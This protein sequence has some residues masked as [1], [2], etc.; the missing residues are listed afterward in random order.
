MTTARNASI[1]TITIGPASAIPLRA[2]WQPEV[3]HTYGRQIL[4]VALAKAGHQRELLEMIAVAFERNGRRATIVIA[5]QHGR[6]VHDRPEQP[7]WT[8]TGLTSRR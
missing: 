1:D 5:H 4:I 6:A 8:R 3:S 7:L 2:A